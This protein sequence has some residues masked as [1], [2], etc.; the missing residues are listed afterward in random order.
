MRTIYK[1]QL[2]DMAKEILVVDDEQKDLDKVKNILEKEGYKVVTSSNGAEALD[3]L[4]EN[5]F[6]LIL[7]DIMMPTLSG[8]DLVRL[9]R[10][11]VNHN[12]PLIYVSV[13][14]RKDVN[15]EGI[16]GF[17]QK[18]FNPENLIAAIKKTL[19]KK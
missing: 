10:E 11:K 7:I 19:S 3:M 8:Y 1:I 17:I 16:D 9:L 13:V 2:S 18:P 15:M 4:I 5:K 6:D 14:P 12:V